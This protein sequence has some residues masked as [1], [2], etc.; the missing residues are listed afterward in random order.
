MHI[1]LLRGLSSSAPEQFQDLVFA[2]P[3]KGAGFHAPSGF[4]SVSKAHGACAQS[5][6]HLSSVTFTYVSSPSSTPGALSHAEV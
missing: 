6:Q 2:L 4:C 1:L 3:L 5:A